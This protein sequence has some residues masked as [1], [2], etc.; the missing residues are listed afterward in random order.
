MK[1]N[2]AYHA[3]K[4]EATNRSGFHRS[5]HQDQLFRSLIVISLLSKGDWR[6]FPREKRKPEMEADQGGRHISNSPAWIIFLLVV[7]QLYDILLFTAVRLFTWTGVAHS[8]HSL[9]TNWT[10]G[11][12]R[13]HYRQR[14]KEFSSSLCVQTGC[15]T[16]SLLSNG[17]RGSFPRG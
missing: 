10:A 3:V 7:G 11:R 2:Q 16:A 5:E 4:S 12:S 13:F 9:T 6:L 14:Q 1:H 15:D 17:Y 8:V